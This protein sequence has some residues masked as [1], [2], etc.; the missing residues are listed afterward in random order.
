MIRFLFI[1]M[2]AAALL[3]ALVGCGSDDNGG[4]N[5]P[6]APFTRLVAAHHQNPGLTSVDSPVWDSIAAGRINLGTDTAYNA[7]LSATSAVTADLKALVSGDSLFV[8]VT[9][10]DA[11]VNNLYG[12]LKAYD[13]NDYIEWHA[14]TFFNED[15]F[16]VVF[17]ENGTGC[18]RFCHSAANAIGRKFYGT[19]S[20]QADIWHWKANRTG[21]A[22]FTTPATLGFAEDM[23]I[24]DTM[25]APDPQTS[26]GDDLYFDNLDVF[27]AK[28]RKMHTTGSAFTGPGLVEGAW[29]TY[30]ESGQHWIDSSVTPPTGRFIPGYYMQNL[31]R[32]NGSR[33]DVRAMA[34]HNGTSWTVVFCRKL[35]TGD[36]DDVD[37]TS[38]APDS[39]LINIAVGNNSGVNHLGYKPFYL[40]VQ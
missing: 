6:P 8:R 22:L 27:T 34:A 32:A 36:P 29:V 10:T 33:W 38:A 23:H 11:S 12:Q 25:V 35:S 20:D 9:W 3:T 7:G 5:P 16:Y 40:V 15:R 2:T 14:E 13:V 17:D 19:V 24:T 1:S 30:I 39:V 21:L 28:A 31:T 26:G 37:L 18:K 4:T